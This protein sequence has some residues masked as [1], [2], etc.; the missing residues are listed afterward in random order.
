MKN[1]NGSDKMLNKFKK[2]VIKDF[3]IDK[4]YYTEY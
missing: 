3:I 4:V 1:L 2:N